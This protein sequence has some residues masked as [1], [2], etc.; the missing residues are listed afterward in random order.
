MSLTS[1]ELA[2]IITFSPEF[3]GEKI[4]TLQET[5]AVLK[6]SNLQL[7]L[8]VKDSHELVSEISV[9]FSFPN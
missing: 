9:F 7:F 6:K 5:I 4:P 2:I 1:T 8:E 3:K